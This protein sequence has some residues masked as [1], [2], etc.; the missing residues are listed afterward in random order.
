MIR[1]FKKKDKKDK[2]K[3]YLYANNHFIKKIKLAEIDDELD[4]VFNNV[5]VVRVLFKKYILGSNNALIIVKP[6]KLKYTNNDKKELHV[7]TKLY[8]GVEA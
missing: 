6:V 8:E 1:L 7:E 4:A 2:W 5:F 3:I